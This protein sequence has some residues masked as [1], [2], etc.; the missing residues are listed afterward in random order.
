[1][2]PQAFTFPGKAILAGSRNSLAVAR[3]GALYSWGWN[4]HD[5]LGQGHSLVHFSP[6]PEPLRSVSCYVSSL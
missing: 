1:M 6:Q 5:T 3:S 2:A 4:S